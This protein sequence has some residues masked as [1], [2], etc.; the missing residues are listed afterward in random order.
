LN[1]EPFW[2]FW[3]RENSPLPE[4]ETLVQGYPL[5][6]LIYPGIPAPLCNLL[7]ICRVELNGM[8]NVEDGQ[9]RAL[10]E[11]AMTHPHAVTNEKHCTEDGQV[12]W[13]GQTG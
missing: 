2:T 11:A 13:Q 8:T 1:P 9:V 5:Y 7:K 12:T 6:R 4:I 3:S 10:K